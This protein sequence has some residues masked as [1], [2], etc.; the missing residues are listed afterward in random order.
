MTI[1]Q[2][3]FDSFTSFN[4]ICLFFLLSSIVLVSGECSCE[5][6]G[7]LGEHKGEAL[8][9][10]LAAIATI[11]FAGALGVSLP[12]LSKKVPA[13][14]PENDVFFMVK[15]FAAGVILA[16]GFVHIIPEAFESLTSPCL[17][18][19]PWG[20]FPFT[21]FVAMM[22][23]IGT[24]MVDSFATGYYKRQHFNK[25]KLLAVV[26]DEEKAGEHEGHVHVHT[27]ATHGHAHG[28]SLDHSSQDLPLPQFIRHRVVSQV[29]LSS[30]Y[31]YVH[32]F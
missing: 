5:E 12:L 30:T 28:G 21:G 6:V 13:L 8:K 9:Y 15:A 29:R 16:T 18:E 23:S 3:C 25:N 14:R 7:D 32:I 1:L 4:L 26:Q 27:H 17:G 11:L 24:L 10:K 22:S 19:N 31:M 20:K 2:P